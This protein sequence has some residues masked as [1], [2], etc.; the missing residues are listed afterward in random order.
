MATSGTTAFS[1]TELEII[2]TAMEDIGLLPSGETLAA[3]DVVRCRRKLNLL[4]KQWVAQ[5]DFAPGLK[6][7]TRRRAYIFLQKS[8]VKYDLGPAG[9]NATETYVQTTLSA[10]AANGASTVTLTSATGI[11][12]DMYIGIVMNSGSVHWTVVNGAPSG[13]VV[14]LTANMAGAATSGNVVF[15]YTTKIRVPFD[16]VTCVRRDING[17]DVPVGTRLSIEDYEAIYSKTQVGTVSSLYFEAGK[18]ASSVYLDF[19]PNDVT[20]VLR[21]VYMS[22]VE[23]LTTTTDSVDFSAE[24]FRPLAAQL[25]MDIA[26]AYNQPVT[27]GMKLLRDESLRMAQNAHPQVTTDYF[28]AE[29]DCYE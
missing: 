3:E 18:T 28:M 20:D 23:D 8:Q 7:W 1:C 27:P 25:A 15:A 14:T 22:Y 24:W 13:S 9:D 11:A 2:T 6:M 4:V 19:A 10:N 29:P 12:D 17:K 16:L 26:P 21:F 5:S